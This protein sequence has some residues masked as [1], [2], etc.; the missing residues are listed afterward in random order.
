MEQVVRP[1]EKFLPG[2]HLIIGEA[3]SG[4]TRLIWSI[5]QEK[6]YVE[7]DS[8]NIVLTDSEKRIWYGPTQNPIITIDPYQTN[9]SW[10]TEP[11][12]PGI[13]YCPCE[14]A[15]RII[16]FLECLATWAIQNEKN[17]DN[18]VRIFVDFPAK[19]WSLPEFVEQLNR[20]H[21]I[22]ASQDSED[23][24]IEIWSVFCSLKKMIPEA[25]IL[26]QDI[27]LVLL[28]PFPENWSNNICKLL[29]LK[30]EN[31][32]ALLEAMNYSLKDGFY[33]IPSSEEEL[34][35]QPNPIEKL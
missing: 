21:Y 15:P 30:C 23:P 33:Y 25:K 6:D 1:F 3:G 34:Y 18:K 14:Y 10:A 16:T 4:K 11:K 24:S 29:D 28:N 32:P 19:F 9:I 2:S 26:F 20:L 22:T 12:K 35:L 17:I 31:L 7:D 5:L 13:Y 8:I 27:N